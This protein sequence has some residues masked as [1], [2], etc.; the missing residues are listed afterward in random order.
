MFDDP[1]KQLQWLEEEL[2]AQEAPKDPENEMDEE[3]FLLHPDDPEYDDFDESSAL[4]VDPKAE[5]RKK[6]ER[7]G[8]VFMALITAAL[9]G[10]MVW[11][12]LSWRR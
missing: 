11:W 8:M 2:H 5:K 3:D 4:L 9:V 7:A 10:T 12:W 1:K 6:R